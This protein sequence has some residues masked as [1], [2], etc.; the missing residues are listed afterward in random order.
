VHL[1]VFNVLKRI[2]GR[3]EVT[4]GCH[5]WSDEDQEG[6]SWLT[7]NGIRT[8]TGRLTAANW[9]HAAPALGSAI[10]A[11][12]PPELVQY[13]TPELHALIAQEHFDVLQVEET[14]LTPYA[15]SLPKGA[16]TKKVLV[17]H[18]V[19][20]V[21]AKRIARIETMRG[22]QVWRDANAA[23][24]RRYEPAIAAEFDRVVAVSD[25]DRSILLDVAPQLTIDV[26]P[27]GVDTKALRPLPEPTSRRSLVFVGTLNYRPC[28]DAVLWL[29]R[30]VLPK[31]RQ[32]FADIDLWIV[33]KEPPPEVEALASEGVYVT[34]RVEDVAPYYERAT[35]AVVPLRAGGGSRLKILEAMALGRPV[36]STSVGAEG[37]EV[38]HGHDILLA[39]DAESFAAAIMQLIDQKETWRTIA[40]NARRFVEERHDWDRI[41]EKQLEI[42][43]ELLQG[44][45]GQAPER[46]RLSRLPA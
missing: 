21:Q 38:T 33:G 28:G 31:L 27:N 8:V 40:G 34:G 46:G 42:Y 29:T 19:H 13:Q 24:M 25:V 43:D 37:L 41:T 2:A 7:R 11:G 45:S 44:K 14:I 1:R 20:F 39:D 18:N 17:F 22:L 26:L 30:E 23:M 35:V 32:R 15:A 4:L 3:H 9:R 5:S 36:V 12:R 6:A 10:F 16:D